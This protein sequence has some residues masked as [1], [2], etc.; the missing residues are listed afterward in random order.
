[1]SKQRK[2]ILFLIAFVIGAAAFVLLHREEER[3]PALSPIREEAI[4][5]ADEKVDE[6]ANGAVL[7]KAEA[8]PE[9]PQSPTDDAPIEPSS[10]PAAA[11]RIMDEASMMTKLR[12]LEFNDLE[13]S[14]DLAREGNERFPDTKDA[15]ERA[16]YIVRCLS[17]LGKFDE[18]EKEAEVMVK[19]YPD[20]TWTSDVYRHVLAH[21]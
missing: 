1:M 3:P 21:P 15:A 11:P 16:W 14:L 6:A 12:A 2:I 10:K 17:R 13:Q 20:T 4:E 18:A 8:K 5:T 9:V 7:P 19:R